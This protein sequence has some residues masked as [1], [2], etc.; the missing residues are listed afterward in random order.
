MNPKKPRI[1]LGLAAI[2]RP[3]YINIRRDSDPD[4]SFSV[5]RERAMELLDFAY[6][7][8]IRDFDTAASYGKGEQ[9]LAEWYDRHQYADLRL[10][11]K[12]GYTYMADWKIGYSGAHEIKEHSLAK[13]DEQWSFARNMLPGLKTYQIHSATFDSGVLGNEEVHERLAELK[14]RHELRIGASVSGRSI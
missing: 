4:K 9:F 11:S 10:S 6:E 5:Y 2:G 1:G 8:G 7:E 12:W 13:L 14:S 3:E